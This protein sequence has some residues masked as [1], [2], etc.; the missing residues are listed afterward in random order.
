MDKILTVPKIIPR[1]M[2]N[3]RSWGQTRRLFEIVPA[4]ECGVC[5]LSIYEITAARLKFQIILQGNEII[6]HMLILKW[7]RL[8]I[9]SV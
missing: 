3:V 9:D 4:F 8:K 1:R 5:F 2:R 7:N 6:H